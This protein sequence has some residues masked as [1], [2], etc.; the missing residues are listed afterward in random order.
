M[1]FR[2]LAEGLK[3]PEGATERF[4]RLEALGRMLDGTLYDDLPYKFEDERDQQRDHV[5]L[6]ERRP[7]VDFPLAY[8]ITQDTLAELFGDEQFPT[9]H[10]AGGREDGKFKDADEAVSDFIEELGLPDVVAQAYEEGVLGAVAV[11]MLRSDNGAP[12]FDVLPAKWCQPVYRS[13]ISTELIGLPVTYPISREKAIA[14]CPSVIED[15][16]GRAAEQFWYRYVVGPYVI[17]EYKPMPAERFSKLGQVDAKTGEP[18]AFERHKETV[19]GFGSLVPALYVKNLVAKHRDLEGP[20]LWWPIRNICVEIDYTLSQCGRGLRYSADPM[21]FVRRGDLFDQDDV[22]A[23]YVPAGGGMATQVTADGSMV[24]GATQTLTGGPGSDAKLLEISANGIKEEREFVRD[25]R[26]YA[27]EVLGGMK[28]RAEHLKAA[29]SGAALDKG[30]KPLR[31]LVRRQ[32]R[33]YGNTLLVGLI[34]LA[35]EGI[36]RGAIARAAIEANIDAIPDG[37]RLVP[38]WPND[39]TLQGQELLYHVQG[40]QMAAGGSAKTPLELLKPDS[41][42]RKIASDLGMHEPYPSIAGTGEPFEVA[43]PAGPG[44]PIVTP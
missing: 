14:L 28:A 42:G 23:G 9:I 40:L 32:R 41:M 18:I 44:S 20:C 5:P 4:R 8:E 33:P 3:L 35:L 34:N 2:E 22:A 39:D 36:R 7:S 31:R 27:L 10:I 29:P 21:L 43:E 17:I 37:A 38:D 15:D 12:F 25:L 26:E 19:H 1:A 11:V 30:L 24:R 6:R 13:P 16:A